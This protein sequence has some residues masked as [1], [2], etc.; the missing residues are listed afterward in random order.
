MKYPLNYEVHTSMCISIGHASPLVSEVYFL[1]EYELLINAFVP[2][3]N[4]LLKE[5]INL[6]MPDP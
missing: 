3:I 2:K 5:G 1:L 4:V 6:A